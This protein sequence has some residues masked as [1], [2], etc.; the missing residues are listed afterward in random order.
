MSLWFSAP[1][2]FN[3]PFDCNLPLQID[4][5]TDEDWILFLRSRIEAEPEKEDFLKQCIT[6]QVWKT[7]PEYLASVKQILKD[8]HRE[9]YTNSSIFCFSGK[10][11]SIPM[12][13]YYADSH[14]GICIEFNFSKENIICG[15]PYEEVNGSGTNYRGQVITASVDYIEDCPELN[16]F[17]LRGSEELVKNLIFAKIDEWEH[18][19]EYRI[20]RRLVA[21]SA[22]PFDSKQLSRVIFGCKA[23]PSCIELVKEWLTEYPTDV[24]LARAT[25]SPSDFALTI[26]DFD[27]V[28]GTP[29]LLTP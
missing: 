22:A 18:E 8:T 3:D 6:E 14:K 16:Y 21:P 28:A 1:K 7:K 24:I 25:T 10:P 19:D 5:A 12:F 29:K 4:S 9:I 2:E 15:I 27:I 26:E 13:S 17:K 23:E 20:Y 11:D